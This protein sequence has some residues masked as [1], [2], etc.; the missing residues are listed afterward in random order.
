MTV[1]ML[2]RDGRP[3]DKPKD[4]PEAKEKKSIYKEVQPAAGALHL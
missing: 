3:A 4:K 1:L 2:A